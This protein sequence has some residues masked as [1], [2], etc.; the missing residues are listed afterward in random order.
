MMLNKIHARP[1]MPPFWK[2]PGVESAEPEI[3]DHVFVTIEQTWERVRRGLLKEIRN[4]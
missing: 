4:A 1:E 2:F 3:Y